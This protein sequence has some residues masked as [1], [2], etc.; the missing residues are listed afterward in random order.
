VAPGSIVV[1]VVVVIDI[2]DGPVKAGVGDGRQ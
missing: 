1:T 2:T